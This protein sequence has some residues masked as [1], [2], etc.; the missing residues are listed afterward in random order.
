MIKPELKS[1]LLLSMISLNVSSIFLILLLENNPNTLSYT[2]FNPSKDEKLKIAFI[3]SFIVA[4]I[5]Y[6][7]Q[8][9]KEIMTGNKDQ[10]NSEFSN[11][12]DS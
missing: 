1:K 10:V 12:Q 8:T 6:F 3:S 11:Q 7:F 2:D 4:G 5:I 9:L